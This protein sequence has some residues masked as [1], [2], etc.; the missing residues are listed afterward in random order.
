[1]HRLQPERVPTLKPAFDKSGSGTVTAANASSFN[2]GASALVLANKELAKQHGKGNRILARICG[3]ADAAIDPIDFPV[4]PAKV[5]PLAMARAGIEQE[6]VAVF[7]INEAF[8]AVIKANAQVSS[9]SLHKQVWL[10]M[11]RLMTCCRFTMAHCRADTFAATD[12]EPADRESQPSRRSNSSRSS[13]RQLRIE[14]YYYAVTSAE[15][16]RVRCCW[17]M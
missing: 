9:D 16:R 10:R 14:D 4:A 11:L 6:Q 2:D 13:A 3:Y 15:E 5:I 7:E 1:V 8:A 12:T 17:D